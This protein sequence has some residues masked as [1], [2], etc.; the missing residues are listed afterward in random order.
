MN[1][2]MVKKQHAHKAIGER[3]KKSKHNGRNEKKI[4]EKK[5]N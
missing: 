3:A 2:S 4:D 1:N 5:L